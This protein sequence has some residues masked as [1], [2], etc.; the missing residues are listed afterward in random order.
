MSSGAD[1]G[2]ITVK[3]VLRYAT[4]LN[5]RAARART[6]DIYA[7]PYEVSAKTARNL[8]AQHGPAKALQELARRATAHELRQR[9]G[10]ERAARAASEHAAH[11]LVAAG[12][13]EA[14]LAQLSLGQRLDVALIGLGVMSQTAAASI[15]GDPVSGSKAGHVVLAG[16]L[17]LDV[18]RL[19]E[20][21]LGL[22]RRV[23][24]TLES[25]RRRL[26][27]EEAA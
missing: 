15:D 12:E 27:E 10:Q 18:Q 9:D 6:A 3:A 20:D 16:R 25:S 17:D 21:A 14:Q 24:R 11:Q 22:V 23:E 8:C 19:C 7:D 13:R 26:V 2:T 5:E 4:T 1:S